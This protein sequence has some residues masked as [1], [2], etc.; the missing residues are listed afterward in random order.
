LPEG[1][2]NDERSAAADADDAWRVA[3]PFTSAASTNR[4]RVALTSNL[5]IEMDLDGPLMENRDVRLRFA[6]RDVVLRP[7]PLEHYMGMGGHLILRRDDGAVFAHLHPSGSY[8]MTARQLFELRAEGKAPLRAAAATNDPICKLPKFNP[9]ASLIHEDVSF[10][11]AFPKAGAY[12]LW[13]QVKVRGE[14]LTGVFDVNV[15][16]RDAARYAATG[17]SW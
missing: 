13:V 10:P 8:S 2:T 15:L 3:S 7:V 1:A 17:R 9:D 6:V 16:P 4:Q 5:W 11:Y 12:R 14:I